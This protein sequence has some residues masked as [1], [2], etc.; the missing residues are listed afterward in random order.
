VSPL[1]T[2]PAGSPEAVAV[3]RRYRDR[4]IRVRKQ[5]AEERAKRVERELLGLEQ[6][7]SRPSRGLGLMAP[8]FR[9]SYGRYG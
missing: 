2:F 5:L 4:E 3:C 6:P 1:R 8:A 9:S 7:K